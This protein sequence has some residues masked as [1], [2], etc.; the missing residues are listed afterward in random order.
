MT[1]L[2]LGLAL[3]KG[4]NQL[5]VSFGIDLPQ[6]GTV[7]KTRTVV[8]SLVLG[9]LITV[10]AAL[11]PA[12]RAT[13]VPPI[14]AVREG[15]MLPPSRWARFGSYPAAATLVGAVILWAIGLFAGSVSTTW[16][17]IA[18]GVGAIALFLGI[19]MLAPKL[20]PPASPVCSE[21][22]PPGSPGPPASSPAA[23]APATRRGRR[24]RHRR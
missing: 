17:L 9:I 16:R 24:R 21:L 4:L 13:R 3:A 2:F 10:G 12:L 1:G 19:S 6:T 15:A 22:R 18:I 7:F 11:R 8:I 23:T 20:V 14:A 5:F